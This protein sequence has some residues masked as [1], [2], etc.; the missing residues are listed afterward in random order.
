ME[1]KRLVSLNVSQGRFE[2]ELCYVW[3]F[4]FIFL[5]KIYN[6]SINYKNLNING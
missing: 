5:V 6:K 2:N 3:F 1:I 4:H